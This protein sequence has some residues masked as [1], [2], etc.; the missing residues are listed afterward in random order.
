MMALSIS[1]V[2]LY[3]SGQTEMQSDGILGD[4]GNDMERCTSGTERKNWKGQKGRH[5][6]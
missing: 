3:H 6:Q 4:N 1:P 5:T 2:Y